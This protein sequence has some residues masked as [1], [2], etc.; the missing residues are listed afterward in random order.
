M[1]T[2]DE[3]NTTVDQ[4]ANFG[5]L[6]ENAAD[7]HQRLVLAVEGV[8][9]KSDLATRSLGV[10]DWV[11]SLKAA[12]HKEICDPEKGELKTQYSEYAN[13][14]LTPASVA[15]ISGVILKVVAFVN[16]TFAVPTIAVYLSVWLLKVGLNYW[17]STKV[18]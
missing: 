2:S 18:N 14:A 17:C 8:A 1:S 12:V 15:A 3:L 5:I 11:E 7:I 4:I 16:P 13:Q 6:D 9:T 10:F